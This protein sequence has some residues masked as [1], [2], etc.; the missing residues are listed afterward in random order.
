MCGGFWESSGETEALRAG[1][2]QGA[3]GSLSVN[4]HGPCCQEVF[5]KISHS[6]SIN[7][8]IFELSPGKR[9]WQKKKNWGVSPL[10]WEFGGPR[11][12]LL[13]PAHG[14]KRMKHRKKLS[15]RDIL[16]CVCVSTSWQKE[17][18]GDGK[19]NVRSGSVTIQFLSVWQI[20][21]NG[22]R[23]HDSVRSTW[24]SHPSELL[25]GKAAG[26]TQTLLG[27]QWGPMLFTLFYFIIMKS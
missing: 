20:L 13:F 1:H 18:L 7:F 23:L 11:S 12:E 5:F 17:M 10:P 19:P 6:I 8:H 21:I 15:M 16:S 3:S 24:G 27:S 4:L 9:W 2:L 14:T 25:E 26:L 22:L